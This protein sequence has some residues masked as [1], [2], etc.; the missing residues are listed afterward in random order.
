MTTIAPLR[1]KLHLQCGATTLI[2]VSEP[3]DSK[4]EKSSVPHH[5]AETLA[6]QQENEGWNSNFNYTANG[7]ARI[8]PLFC[9]QSPAFWPLSTIS[10]AAMRNCTC[11]L[12]KNAV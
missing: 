3:D 1:L 11:R 12:R 4:R 8:E 10:P 5:A 7:L 6:S 2:R 9:T